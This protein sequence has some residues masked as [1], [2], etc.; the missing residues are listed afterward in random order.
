M[1]AGQKPL[2]VVIM[3]TVV[4]AIVGVASSIA[5]ILGKLSSDAAMGIWGAMLA[6]AFKNGYA[7]LNSQG[8]V[9][10]GGSKAKSPPRARSR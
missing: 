6:Y 4:L 3:E 2:A 8:K 9:I 5:L 7:Y 10:N 1:S